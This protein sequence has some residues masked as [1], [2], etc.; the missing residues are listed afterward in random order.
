LPDG[1]RR[2]LVV[3]ASSPHGRR[4]IVLFETLTSRDDSD[5]LHGCTLLAEPLASD[6]DDLYVHELIGARVVD[7]AGVLHGTV[8]GVEANPASDL[9]VVDGKWYVPARFV[10]SQAGGEVVVDVPDGLF[11]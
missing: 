9:L 7:T 11:E 2:D 1:G 4:F 6:A 10:V 5:L 3:A 8:T